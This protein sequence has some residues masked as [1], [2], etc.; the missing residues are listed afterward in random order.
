MELEDKKILAE[1]MGWEIIDHPFKYEVASQYCF[2]PEKIPESVW[3][4]DKDYNQF[5]ELE[6]HL[7][8][9]GIWHIYL[10]LIGNVI[11][12][13]PVISKETAMTHGLTISI[14]SKCKV[15]L[16]IVKMKKHG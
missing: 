3:N 11:L 14:K 10:E 5:K 4:P 15:I 8:E 12:F 1:W 6:K 16:E 7:E 2:G 9:T 13:D